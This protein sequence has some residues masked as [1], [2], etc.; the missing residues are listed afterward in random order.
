MGYG[1]LEDLSKRTACDK[2]LSDKTFD[3]AE[4]PKCEEYQRRRT[5]MVHKYF[6]K[7][8]GGTSAHT[9]T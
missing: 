7:K 1:Y 4:N 8:S 6:R 9:G 2:I 5:P 3:I